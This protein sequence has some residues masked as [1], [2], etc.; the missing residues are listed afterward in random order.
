MFE[1]PPR[2]MYSMHLLFAETEFSY[3]THCR[4]ERDLKGHLVQPATQ[5]LSPHALNSSDE[6][7]QL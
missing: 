2:T 7:N 5:Y 1:T 3:S 4:G 6:I